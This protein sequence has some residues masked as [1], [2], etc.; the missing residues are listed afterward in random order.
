MEQ[1]RDSS[2]ELGRHQNAE[3]GIL[4]LY[5]R[6]TVIDIMGTSSNLVASLVLT[7]IA[8]MELGW[9]NLP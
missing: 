2:L 6:Y 9:A 3:L 7:E 8:L 4:A 5:I 1:V